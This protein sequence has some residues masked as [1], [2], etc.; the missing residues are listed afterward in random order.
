[1]NNHP[2]ITLL[3]GLLV[4][5]ACAGAAAQI[6]VN[7]TLDDSWGEP[8]GGAWDGNT[9]WITADGRGQIYVLVRSKPYVR[10]FNRDGK[11]LR[12]WSGEAEIGSAHSITAMWCASTTRAASF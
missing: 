7:Y 5:L 11:F 3:A 1:M 9:S 2:V 12:A 4:C 10:I 8:P 6:N